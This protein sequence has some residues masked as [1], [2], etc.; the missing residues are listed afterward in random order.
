LNAAV[1]VDDQP[2]AMLA[3]LGGHPERV[4]HQGGGLG[5]VDRPADHQSRERV[6]DRGAVDLALAGRVLGDV[7]QPQ[8][9]GSIATKHSA[10][11]V[12]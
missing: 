10:D 3:A 11:Q 1:R 7:S 9:V 12:Q 2:I 6:Q 8:L 5:G 4:E